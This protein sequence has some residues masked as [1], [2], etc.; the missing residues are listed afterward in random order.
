MNLSPKEERLIDTRITLPSTNA[1]ESI[2]KT[3]KESPEQVECYQGARQEEKCFLKF[4]TGS[5][6]SEKG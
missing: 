5:R 6:V 2:L 4:R 1:S 3:I